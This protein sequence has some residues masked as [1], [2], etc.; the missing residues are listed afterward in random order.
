[1]GYTIECTNPQCDYNELLYS[2]IGYFYPTVYLDTM[3]A[4]RSGQGSEM[5]N[6]FLMEHPDG[7]INVENK[8]YR[9]GCGNLCSEEALDMYVPKDSGNKPAAAKLEDK[10]C[11]FPDDIKKNYKLFMRYPHTCSLCNG[12]MKVT[13]KIDPET[14]KC[15]CCGSRLRVGMAMV[16]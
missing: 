16:D 14:E 2:G 11:L 10:H 12:K 4:A 5:H 15:P 7:V 9:C 3:R 6:Q 1:M 13:R 8:M